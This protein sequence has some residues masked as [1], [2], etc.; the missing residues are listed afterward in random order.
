MK[1]FIKYESDLQVKPKVKSKIDPNILLP[2]IISAIAII[3]SAI[4]TKL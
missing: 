4:I 3:S 1:I 2:A